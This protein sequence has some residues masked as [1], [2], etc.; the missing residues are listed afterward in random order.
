MKPI[1]QKTIV[2]ILSAAATATAFAAADPAP[3]RYNVRWTSP[4][5]DSAGSMPLGNGDIALNVWVEQDGD[6]LF[7]IAKTDAWSENNRPLKLGRARVHF[8]PN[9]FVA[10]TPFDQTLHLETATITI[11]AGD[12]E[13][14]LHLRVWVDAHH[15]I[16]HVDGQSATPRS[17]T[18]SLETWRTQRRE[19]TGDEMKSFWDPQKGPDPVFVEPDTV[20][21]RAG[22]RVVWYH[23][24]ERS[25]WPAN[26]KLQ[27]LEPPMTE[28]PDP[29]LHRTF[30]GAIIGEGLSRRNDTTLAST[31]PLSRIDLALHLLT[32]RT[33]T[34]DAWRTQLNAQ[35]AR[36]DALDPTARREAH[37]RWWADFWSRSYIHVTG[38]GETAAVAR[39]YALQRF[40]NAC[41]GRGALPIKFNGSFFTVD[42]RENNETFDADY[43]RWGGPYWWQNTRLPYWSMLTAGDYDLMQPLFGMYLD[44]VPLARARTRIYYNHDGLFFP[45]TITFWGTYANR[46]YGWDR[47]D[48]PVGFVTNPYI[49][50]YWQGGLELT[51]M[52]LDYADHTADERFLR[53]RLVPFAD[54]VV[55]FYAE[56]YPRDENGKLRIEP[57]Q[58]LETYWNVP[59]PAPPIAG[60]MHVLP[61]LLN[62]PLSLATDVQRARWQDL[63]AALPP[64]PRRDA[65]GETILAP[66]ERVG[67][68]TNVENPELYAVFPY[69]VYGVGRPDLDLARRTFR[70]RLHKNT[71]GWG[72]DAIH[73]A[74]LGLTDEAAPRVVQRFSTPNADSRFPAFWGPNYDWVPDQDH[75]SVASIALQRMLIQADDRRIWLLPAWP[76]SWNV[77][78]RLHAPHQTVVEGSYQ[79]GRLARL[80]IT[81]PERR[82]DVI[83]MQ[84]MR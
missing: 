35:I 81:P 10:G 52:M 71:P 16:I 24:N 17:V 21:P 55:T 83:N 66:A 76:R 56:H 33:P 84:D 19:I 11:R 72:Q 50:Y 4:S 31:T 9:P 62:L 73:A 20:L 45:E 41:A 51:A 6:L 8:D 63:L 3:D 7:Y 22:D 64:L 42:A 15:P 44:M 40:I 75:G 69:R 43:R 57:A 82:R 26:M 18:V 68:K 79:D 29:L 74:C 61:R 58:A 23:R 78:F 34:A 65:D 67:K 36:T 54:G 12:P 60:L 30:G 5:R 2:T 32:A 48:H 25:L 59:N 37:E 77:D 53:D 39:G 38:P 49:R 1:A 46:D 13:T 47:A 80:T 27:S 70:H 14:Q 28:L